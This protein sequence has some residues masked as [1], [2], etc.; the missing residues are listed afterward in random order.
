MVILANEDYL[1]QLWQQ[2]QHNNKI[3]MH[4][5]NQTVLLP[6]TGNSTN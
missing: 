5:Q 4:Q 6:L 3:K 1:K 2:E